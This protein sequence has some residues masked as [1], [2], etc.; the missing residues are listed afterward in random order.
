MS[1]NAVP[2]GTV[3]GAEHQNTS[4]IAN[5]GEGPIRSSLKKGHVWGEEFGAGKYPEV[6]GEMPAPNGV[7]KSQSSGMRGGKKG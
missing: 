2:E 7:G 5:M 4:G 6:G 1:M 3:P